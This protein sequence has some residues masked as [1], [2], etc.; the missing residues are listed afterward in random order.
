[1]SKN[2]RRIYATKPHSDLV[3]VAAVPAL[4]DTSQAYV[5]LVKLKREFDAYL[6]GYVEYTPTEAQ[7]LQRTIADLSDSLEQAHRFNRSLM[8]AFRYEAR[9]IGVIREQETG[10]ESTLRSRS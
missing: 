6:N 3:G 5:T 4:I 8:A 2:I 10:R 9:V 1:M 7:A